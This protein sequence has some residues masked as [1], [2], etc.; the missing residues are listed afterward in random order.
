[1]DGKVKSKY[2]TGG[3][4]RGAPTHKNDH[5]LSVYDKERNSSQILFLKKDKEE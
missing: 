4:I 1:M 2:E 3:K 5:L